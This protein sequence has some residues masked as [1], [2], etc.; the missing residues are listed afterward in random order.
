MMTAIVKRI[1]SCSLNTWRALDFFA[2]SYTGLPFS[3]KFKGIHT[4]SARIS[5]VQLTTADHKS[6]DLPLTCPGCGAFCHMQDPAVVG[7]YSTTR[8]PVERFI[9][10]ESATTDSVRH[11]ESKIYRQALTRASQSLLDQLGS[12]KSTGKSTAY[13]KDILSILKSRT[14]LII[15]SIM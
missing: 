1:T 2:I 5:R 10:N 9:E 8:R 11:R 14:R 13:H 6:N 3:N 7:F 12:Q 4:E 15:P